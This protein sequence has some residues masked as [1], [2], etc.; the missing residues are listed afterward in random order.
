MLAVF[1]AL[2]RD[3]WLAQM[4]SRTVARVEGCRWRAILLRSDTAQFGLQCANESWLP[5][6]H[7]VLV[8]LS[9]DVSEMCLAPGLLGMEEEPNSNPP[10]AISYIP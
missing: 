4:S 2:A 1:V 8:K 5:R 7:R 3:D 6:V 10:R 9:L